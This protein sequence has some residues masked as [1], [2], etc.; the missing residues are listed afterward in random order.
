MKKIIT[1]TILLVVFLSGVLGTAMSARAFECNFNFK[2]T[3]MFL[4][5]IY[6]L[7]K[8]SLA[9]NK[10]SNKPMEGYNNFRFKNKYVEIGFF[11]VITGAIMYTVVFNALDYFPHTIGGYIGF[12]I[13]VVGLCIERLNSAKYIRILSNNKLK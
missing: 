1:K 13:Y 8:S 12:V 6:S 5:G 9:L 4:I 3:L 7:F 11:L 10:E 2:T